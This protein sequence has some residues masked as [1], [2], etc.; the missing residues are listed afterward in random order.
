MLRIAT[1]RG[2]FVEPINSIATQSFSKGGD[3]V[4]VLDVGFI[5]PRKIKRQT[6][7][8]D[9][10]VSLGATGQR[11]V[12][13]ADWYGLGHKVALLPTCTPT[14]QLTGVLKAQAYCPRPQRLAPRPF[15]YE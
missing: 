6:V 12:S 7:E 1:V 5:H 9:G 3:L 4:A 13:G 14:A 11:S 2:R 8:R 10:E 15:F